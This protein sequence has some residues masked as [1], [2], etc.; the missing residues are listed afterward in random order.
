MADLRSQPR[1]FP[2][3]VSWFWDTKNFLEVIY[4]RLESAQ[5][6]ETYLRSLIQMLVPS[7]RE[8]CGTFS[9]STRSEDMRL[10]KRDCNR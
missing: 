5:N 2:A 1:A 4:L 10:G 8:G 6:V 7:K 3:G 9:P